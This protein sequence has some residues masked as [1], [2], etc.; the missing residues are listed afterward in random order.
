[1]IPSRGKISLFPPKRPDRL[2]GPPSFLPNGFRTRCH[3]GEDDHPSPL[4]PRFRMSG[5]VTQFPNTPSWHVQGQ[6]LPQVCRDINISKQERFSHFRLE[7]LLAL[8]RMSS[9]ISVCITVYGNG[10]CYS[11][12]CACAELGIFLTFNLTLIPLTWRIG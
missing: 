8:N 2:W 12:R 9:A 6:T 11:T 7:I 4:V 10:Q 5:T 1:L 3:E